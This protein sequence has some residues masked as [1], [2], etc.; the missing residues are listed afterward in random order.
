MV[1]E[2]KYIVITEVLLI[3]MS[4]ILWKLFHWR[5]FLLAGVFFVFIAVMTLCFFRDP[6][7]HIAEGHR[8]VVSPADGKIVRIDETAHLPFSET[9]LKTVSIYLSLWNVHIN[10]VPIAGKVIS[11][12]YR[13]GRFY[14]SFHK[15]APKVNE[16][17]TIGI[18]GKWGVVFFRQIAGLIARRIVCHLRIG[19]HV[20]RGDRFG[21]IIFGSRVEFYLPESVDLLVSVGERVWG[22]ESIIGVFRHDA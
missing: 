6:K 5:G 19:D 10:R 21:M 13:R 18:E 20:K 15:A 2:A 16:Q 9:P 4:C 7:R 3:V 8:I 14:P 22:G 17:N 11:L 1:K 12:N